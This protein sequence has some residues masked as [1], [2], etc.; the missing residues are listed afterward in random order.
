[1]LVG[2]PH[3]PDCN[4]ATP[5]RACKISFHE[6]GMSVVL[7]PAA[8]NRAGRGS[9]A[10]EHRRVSVRPSEGGGSIQTER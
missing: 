10:L 1:M 4:E 6:H 9:L 2:S 5:V 8:D 3:G 7:L